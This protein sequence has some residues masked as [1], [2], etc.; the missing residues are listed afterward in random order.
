MDC[1]SKIT[2]EDPKIRSQWLAAEATVKAKGGSFKEA[3]ELLSEAIRPLIQMTF[4]T[5]TIDVGA[6]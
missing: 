3:I 2:I 6:I 1:P 5:S 4:D